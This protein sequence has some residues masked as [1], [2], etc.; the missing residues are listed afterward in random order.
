MTNI[1]GYVSPE[2]QREIDALM[3]ERREA[4]TK[5]EKQQA[6]EKIDQ[7]VQDDSKKMNDR[8]N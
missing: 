1:P 4:E 3:R 6:R 8:M 7:K 2:N 5:E